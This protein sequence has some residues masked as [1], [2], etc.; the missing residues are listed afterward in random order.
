MGVATIGSF[1]GFVQ[2]DNFQFASSRAYASEISE[3]NA[4]LNYGIYYE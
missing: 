1:S 2:T 3:I 4:A